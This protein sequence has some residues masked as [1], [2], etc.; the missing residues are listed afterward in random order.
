MAMS[1]QIVVLVGGVGG[2]KLALGLSKVVPPEK[3][4]V[5]R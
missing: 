3:F 4:D 2:A 5:Y 1:E